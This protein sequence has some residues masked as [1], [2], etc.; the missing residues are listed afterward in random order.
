MTVISA[1]FR[2]NYD[3]FKARV[4]RALPQHMSLNVGGMDD[5][6][7][8]DTRDVG[9]EPQKNVPRTIDKDEHALLFE[10]AAEYCA[11]ESFYITLCAYNKR[12]RRIGPEGSNDDYLDDKKMLKEGYPPEKIKHIGSFNEIL[13]IIQNRMLHNIFAIQGP[14]GEG[15]SKF[16]I[17]GR[18]NTA[19]KE[20]IERAETAE[21]IGRLLERIFAEKARD[22][23]DFGLSV[24]ELRAITNAAARW[25][26]EEGYL[27]TR[28]KLDGDTPESDLE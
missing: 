11:D 21:Q 17:V 20:P 24:T 19:D 25:Y 8:G 28:K 18:V 4:L 15:D 7:V 26:D 2:A 16:T 1:Y 22:Q 12:H 10:R 27:L 6:V 5:T 14:G 9:I 23:R 13:G 3:D